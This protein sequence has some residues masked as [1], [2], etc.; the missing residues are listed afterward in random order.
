MVIKTKYFGEVQINEEKVIKF[1][2]GIP[3]FENLHRFLFMT[4]PNPD[5]AFYWLQSIDD[6]NIV[7]TIVD[8]FRYLPDYNP[9]VEI[10]SM[11]GLGEYGKIEE[12][13]A[14]Y[15]IANIPSNYKE[16]TIN[17]KAP[18]VINLKT[19]KAKQIIC[20]N[21]E[22]PIRFRIYDLFQQKEGN[23]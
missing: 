21:E 6:V 2:S 14:I 23:D 11:E 4:S 19:Y 16:M 20:N 1:E 22:Y 10:S 12:D 5:S 9:I 3:G 17:L 15:N 18:I 7:F 13:I 8:I